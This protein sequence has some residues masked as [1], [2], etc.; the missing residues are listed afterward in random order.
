MVYQQAKKIALNEARKDAFSKCMIVREWTH[1]G[2]APCKFHDTTY[3][4]RMI[5]TILSGTSVSILDN[6]YDEDDEDSV[7][8][9]EIYVEASF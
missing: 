5:C 8:N 6:Y 1:S 3:C 7:D 4:N 2:K 9:L